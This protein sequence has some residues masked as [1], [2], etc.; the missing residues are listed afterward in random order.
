M[1]DDPEL[2]R[3]WAEQHA[4]K[5]FAELVRRH[6]DLV[7]AVA[8]R[9]VGGDAHLAEDVTQRVF[10]DLARKAAAVARHPVL[11]GWLFTSTHYAAT[12][13]VRAERRRRERE[14]KAHAMNE[15]LNDDSAALDG[16]R[17][18]P[19]L[20]DLVLELN[21]RDREA[22]LLRFFEGRGFAEVGAR[23]QL[24]E[25]GARARVDRAIDKLQALLARRGITSTSGALGL[26]LANQAGAAAPA[27]LVASVTALAVGGVP[28]VSALAFMSMAKIT[29]GTVVAAAVLGL[30]LTT[31]LYLVAR[32]P[33]PRVSAEHAHAAEESVPVASEAQPSLALVSEMDLALLRDEMRVAGAGEAS[34]RAALEGILR[35][36]YRERLSQERTARAQRGWWRDH[37]RTWGTAASSQRLIDDPRLLR[38]MVTTRLEELLG[39]DPIAVA[40]ADVRYGFLPS[41]MRQTLARLDREQPTGWSPTGI[42]EVDAR[43]R[44]EFET[45]RKATEHKRRELI[46]AMTPEQRMDYEMRT[47]PFAAA[48]IRQ[49]QAIDVTE[50]EFRTV[51]PLADA[52][53]KEFAA[54]GRG[55]RSEQLELSRQAAEKLVAALGYERAL[56]YIWCGAME[57]PAYAR[58]VREQNLA[59]NAAGQAVQ[60]AAETAEKAGSIHADAKLSVAEKRS[61]LANLQGEAQMQFDR[62]IPPAAQRRLPVH[63]LTWLAA[64][65]EGRYKGIG[66]VMP[67]QTGTMVMAATTDVSDPPAPPT[68]P[69]Q[70]VPRRATGG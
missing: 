55:S 6:V 50:Q 60:L 34:I 32:E 17:L 54:A 38:E 61:A 30:S 39:P 26:A 33:V 9:K 19:L 42:A 48:L 35:R 5:A 45:E 65:G 70:F 13:L 69:K 14:Q 29:G 28:V 57:Y 27:G 36:R 1:I 18:R 15:L 24:S 66:T 51:F 10:A 8:L 7:F 41:E 31:N 52:H 64:L 44:D 12:Q 67:G 4:E 68:A 37:Q 49:L 47:S 11:T 16:E 58:L 22:V 53:A 43:L 40:E 21:E 20:D 23:L 46:A 59:A 56:D 25:D 2:L 62:L 63:S 3:Q